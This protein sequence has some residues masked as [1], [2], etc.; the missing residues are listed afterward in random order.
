MHRQ[1]AESAVPTFESHSTFPSST[2]VLATFLQ[3]QLIFTC[4]NS[5]YVSVYRGIRAWGFR[6]RSIFAPWPRASGSL[7]Q[8]SRVFVAATTIRQ[9]INKHPS[10]LFVLPRSLRYAFGSCCIDGCRST[11]D[12]VA[13]WHICSLTAHCRLSR[14]SAR[15]RCFWCS[16]SSPWQ[17]P[18]P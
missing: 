12:D 15:P 13:S 2:L 5:M 18:L 6:V 14:A 1:D 11:R 9:H 4:R 7:M 16:W 3:N 17:Q 10:P 8:S